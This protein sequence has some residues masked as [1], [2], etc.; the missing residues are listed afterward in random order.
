MP[1]EQLKVVSVP[2][3]DLVGITAAAE[4]ADPEDVRTWLVPYRN[5]LRPT[6]RCPPAALTPRISSR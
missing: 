4:A 1:A 6:S 3:W 5:V 2:F